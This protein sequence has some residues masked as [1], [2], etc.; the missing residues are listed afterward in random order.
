MVRSVP[1]PS[2]P[3]F[4]A[5]LVMVGADRYSKE[6]GNVALWP[7]EFVTTTFFIPAETAAAIAFPVVQLIEVAAS[8]VGVQVTPPILTVVS[9][10]VVRNPDPDI[11]TSVPPERG[12]KSGVM[13]LTVGAGR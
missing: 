6:V 2:A 10:T 3:T 8:A 12:P 1:P 13:A 11:V 4:G 5:I 7:S 9:P